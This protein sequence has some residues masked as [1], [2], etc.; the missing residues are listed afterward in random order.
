MS[1]IKKL[2]VKLF[3]VNGCHSCP[4]VK[5]ARTPGAGY[6][7]DFHCSLTGTMVAFYVEWPSE[8]RKDGDFPKDCPLKTKR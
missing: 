5:D 4:H 7:L 1:G 8:K 3:E 6:A 2:K